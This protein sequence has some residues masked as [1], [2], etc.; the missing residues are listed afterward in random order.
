LKKDPIHL[1]NILLKMQGRHINMTLIGAP[2]ED[3]EL[4]QDDDGEKE[5]PSNNYFSSHPATRERA[6]VAR[7]RSEEF[8][9]GLQ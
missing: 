6:R 9:K 5:A 2:T 1:A 7:Q 8:R 3:S 4:N